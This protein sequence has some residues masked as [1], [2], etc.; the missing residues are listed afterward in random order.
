M[1]ILI[2][3]PYLPHPR[4]LHGTGVFM[5]GLLQ[6]LSQR[7][8]ITLISF[9]DEAEALLVTGLKALPLEVHTIP[10]AKGRQ[11]GLW[12]NALLAITRILQLAL[13]VLFWQPYYVRKFRDRRMARTIEEISAQRRFDIVQLEFA[14]MAQYAKYV[15]GGKVVLHEHDV[16]FR[17]AYRRYKK[18]RSVFE[19]AVMFLEWCRWAR[20]EP[21]LVRRFDHVLT[22]TDQDRRLLERISGTHHI[23][24]LPR[25]VDSDDHVPVYERREPGSLLFVGTFAHHPNVDA[26]YW[27]LKEIYPLILEKY[28]ETILYIVG[29]DPPAGLYQLARENTRVRI[30]GYVNDIVPYL[31][32]CAVFVAPLRYGGGVKL[33]IIHAMAQGIPVVTTRV[34][35]EGIDGLTYES[36]LVGNSPRT[37]AEAVCSLLGNPSLAGRIGARGHDL[38]Q[39]WYS[40]KSTARRLEEIYAAVTS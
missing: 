23:S 1:D 21:A 13:S 8:R 19:K 39:Q 40:W 16:T 36:A 32:E 4:A 14:Q 18:S 24:Y 37:I 15:R 22:V 17:P 12:A 29:S 10:R 20:Y 31:R 2:I 26:V 9:C 27:L 35:C 38:V 11:P 30:L 25:G 33:K 6:Q 5:F 7:H 3:T 34:G 28:P